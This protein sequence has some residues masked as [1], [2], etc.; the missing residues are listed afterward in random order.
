MQHPNYNPTWGGPTTHIHFW[1]GQA[2]PHMPQA[3]AQQLTTQPLTI[4]AYPTQQPPPLQNFHYAPGLPAPAQP[5]E[6]DKLLKSLAQLETTVKSQQEEATNRMAQ[7]ETA[8]K[9]Q[10]QEAAAALKHFVVEQIAEWRTWKDSDEPQLF[11]KRSKAE[12]AQDRQ[13][14]ESREPERKP[15]APPMHRPA[16]VGLQGERTTTKPEDKPTALQSRTGQESQTMKHTGT[17]RHMPPSLE[18]QRPAQQTTL[19]KRAFSD[20]LGIFAKPSNPRLAQKNKAQP[21]IPPWRI[22]KGGHLKTRLQSPC[23][24]NAPLPFEPTGQEIARIS[25]TPTHDEYEHT[26]LLPPLADIDGKAINREHP[27]F[28]TVPTWEVDQFQTDQDGQNP[29]FN[30]IASSTQSLQCRLARPVV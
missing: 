3:P 20:P 2:A 23:S 27:P 13:Y 30:A 10:Q 14:S 21:T 7:L 22:S 12:P 28:D 24:E 9:A 5:P 16:R 25:P 18:D 19:S 4:M 26:G 29:T 11:R 8:V 17:K 15:H 6:Q 1:G